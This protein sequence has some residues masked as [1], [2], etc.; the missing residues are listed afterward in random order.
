MSKAISPGSVS[1]GQNSG[2]IKERLEQLELQDFAFEAA[3]VVF[4]DAFGAQGHPVR[5]TVSEMGPLLL[6][7]MLNLNETQAGVLTAAFKIA[8]DEGLLLLDLKDLRA[9]L[10]HVGGERKGL[11]HPLRQYLV[12]VGGCNPARTP[13]S[14]AAGR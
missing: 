12:G 7:R 8:D 3:P 1:P 2:R 10:T 4:W 14:R 5:T 11:H 6:A 9:M 13:V